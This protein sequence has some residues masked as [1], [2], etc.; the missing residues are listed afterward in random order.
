[1]RMDLR[2]ALYRISMV[3]VGVSLS[4]SDDTS[5]LERDVPRA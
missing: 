1:L 3:S 4:I 5:L 2:I